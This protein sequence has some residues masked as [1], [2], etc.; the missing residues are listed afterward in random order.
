MNNPLDVKE[1]DEYAL[2]CALHRSHLFS[3]SVSL[4]FPC[5]THAFFPNA[6]LIIAGVSITV[7]EI[8]TKFDAVPLSDLSQNHIRPDTQLQ[9]KGRKNQYGYHLPLHCTTTTAVHMA[10]S[11]PEITDGSDRI[12][13][14][15][16]LHTFLYLF[17]EVCGGICCLQ[18]HIRVLLP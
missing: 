3:V 6:C 5:T 9:I 13:F 2:D 15:F 18:L 12:F 7:S 14:F 10:T 1:N 8:C 4:D 17:S 11:V 16:F